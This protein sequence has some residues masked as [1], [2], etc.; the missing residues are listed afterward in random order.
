MDVPASLSRYRSSVDAALSELF[1]DRP[2][3]LFEMMRHQLGWEGGVLQ[4]GGKYLRPSLLLLTAESCMADWRR[5]LPGAVGLEFLHNFSLIHDDIQ[6]ESSLRRNRPTVWTQWG[7]AQAI[8]AGDGM[9]A[10]S[11]IVVLRLIEDG[12]PALDVLHAA[13]ML[14][15]MCLA[16]CEGQYADMEFEDRVFVS[17]SEYKEMIGNKTAAAFRC[18]LEMGSRL[19]A[20]SDEQSRLLGEAGF[21]M[22]LA[23]QIRDDV[24]DL[25]GGPA[26]GKE[27]ALD[28]R[29]GKKSLPVVFGLSQQQSPD[30]KKLHEIYERGIDDD[31]VQEVVRLLESLGAPEFCAAEADTHW[32]AG[33]SLIESSGLPDEG[34]QLLAEIGEYLVK[35]PS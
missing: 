32:A 8:N 26:I 11:Q 12:V 10:L 22:G 35:R 18:A 15:E 34:I 7:A 5:L 24:L 4:H 33:R 28:I 14:D 23:F 21:E 1:E 17:I 30:G 13:R 3:P 9:H 19:A 16:L 2:G 25:W 31:D 6:D 20:N 27:V 29:G